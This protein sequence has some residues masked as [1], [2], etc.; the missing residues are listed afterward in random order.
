CPPVPV[1]KIPE[2]PRV[3][4]II[5]PPS[6]IET[7]PVKIKKKR[8]A[9]KGL[10]NRCSTEKPEGPIKVP[11]P[12]PPERKLTVPN[13]GGPPVEQVAPPAVPA[14]IKPQPEAKPA[15]APATPPKT[16]AKV[17]QEVVPE[18]P[19]EKPEQPAQAPE[20]TSCAPT[21]QDKPKAM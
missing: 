9:K 15:E 14:E 10:R 20:K 2:A 8:L 13:L 12:P 11:Q 6:A 3:P 17:E 5:T 16:P 7:P 18:K 4:K 1:V 21:G 19:A